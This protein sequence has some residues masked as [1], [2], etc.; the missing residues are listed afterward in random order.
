MSHLW[1]SVD[2]MGVVS[3]PRKERQPQ[4]CCGRF[5]IP[6]LASASS[7]CPLF[8]RCGLGKGKMEGKMEGKVSHSTGRVMDLRLGRGRG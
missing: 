8:L 5:E 1:G 4:L 2:R 3:D 7:L 6:V